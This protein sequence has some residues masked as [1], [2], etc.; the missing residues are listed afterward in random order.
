MSSFVNDAW[1][2]A[3]QKKEFYDGQTTLVVYSPLYNIFYTI[4]AISLF[5]AGLYALSDAWESGLTL[6]GKLF[7]LFAAMFYTPLYLAYRVYQLKNPGVQL[8]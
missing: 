4:F 7:K 2:K 1:E 3:S 8:F 5:V 6:T